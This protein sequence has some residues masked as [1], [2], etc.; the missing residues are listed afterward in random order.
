MVPERPLGPR[1]GR[2]GGRRRRRWARG[3]GSSKNTPV[4]P[5]TVVS[6]NP[7]QRNAAVGLAEGGRLHRGQSEVLVGGGHQARQR[8]RYSQR[9]PASVHPAQHGHVGRGARPQIALGQR[10][11]CPRPPAAGRAGGGRPRPPPPRSCRG[12][13]STRTGRSPGSMPSTA[14]TGP[15]DVEVHRRGGRRRRRSRRASATRARTARELTRYRSAV[16]AARRSQRRSG[17]ARTA[18]PAAARREEPPRYCSVWY[19]QRAGV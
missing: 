15:V 5:S 14:S 2:P 6:R 3:S 9:S 16:A 1:R 11:R 17:G 4:V 10:A 12:A 7:P 19:S 8:D 13:A 18:R